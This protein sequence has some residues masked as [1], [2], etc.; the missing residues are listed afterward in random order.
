MPGP[1]EPGWG[2]WGAGPCLSPLLSPLPCI[3]QIKSEFGVSQTFVSAKYR[4]T[5]Y[6]WLSV[7]ITQ[8][9][10]A[11][12]EENIQ[13]NNLTKKQHEVVVP[14]QE[15]VPGIWGFQWFK[16]PNVTGFASI[17][18][19]GLSHSIAVGMNGGV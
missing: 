5:L 19:A 12:L 18:A 17:R 7:S 1:G 13:P 4:E 3:S 8:I 10:R 2:R 6:A 9:P 11:A 15:L 14:G 16:P